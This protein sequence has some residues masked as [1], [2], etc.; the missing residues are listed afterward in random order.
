MDN[1]KNL[2]QRDGFINRHTNGLP[3][4]K[5][6]IRIIVSDVSGEDIFLCEWNPF[7]KSQYSETDMPSE[8]YL[9]TARV[10]FGRYSGIG[11]HAWEQNNSEFIWYKIV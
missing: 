5:C 7:D 8:G 3:D 6:A 11:H 2:Q 4:H 9:G 10:I 1:M